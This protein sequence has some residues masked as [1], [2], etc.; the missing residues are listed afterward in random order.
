MFTLPRLCCLLL[1]STAATASAANLYKW[2]DAN[3]VTQYSER[4]PAGKQYETR[5]ITASGASVAEP[6]AAAEAGESEQCLG[7]RKNLDLLN[8][9]GP[10]T[11]GVGADGK[12]GAPLDDAQ[13][14]AQKQLAEAVAA[15]YC[16]S[17][18][19]K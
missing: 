13:R 15:V 10:V 16:K 11:H 5:R 9:S 4:P 2:K 8:G 7:A 12:P 17:A 3:G 18:P 1:L 14:A 6:V 19:N